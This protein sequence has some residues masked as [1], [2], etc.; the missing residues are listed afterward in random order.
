MSAGPLRPPRTTKLDQIL[1][2]IEVLPEKIS[3]RKAYPW[4]IPALAKLER[5]ELHPHVTFFVGEN[6]SGKSTLVEA[7]AIKAGFNREGGTGGRMLRPR[8]SS[9]SRDPGIRSRSR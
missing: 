5:L 4:T 2:H 6:G 3:D 7:L 1:R 8:V 9:P